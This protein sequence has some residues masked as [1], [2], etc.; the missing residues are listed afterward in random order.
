MGTPTDRPTN[1]ADSF[2]KEMA[3]WTPDQLRKATAMDPTL[4]RM[5]NE[6]LSL[7]I[8]KWQPRPDDPDQ[9][10]EQESFVTSTAKFAIGLGG[11][12]AGKTSAAAYK[13]ARYVL[14]KPAPRRDTP[15]W[16]I[17]EGYDLTCAVC[18]EEKLRNFIPESAI[19]EIDWYKKSR[20]WPNAVVLKD[21]HNTGTNWV[22]EFK[23]YMQGRSRMQARSIGGFWFNEEVPF[24]I[25][26]EVQARCRDYDSPGWADFTPI[27]IRDQEWPDAYEDPPEGWEFFHLNTAC[28]KRLADGWFERWI[29]SIPADMRDTRQYGTFATFKGQIFKEW[30][31]RHNII[32]WQKPEDR[33]RTRK[34]CPWLTDDLLVWNEKTKEY[35]LD[36]IKMHYAIPDTW[37]RVRGMDFGFNDPTVCVWLVKDRDQ[38]WFVVDEHFLNQATIA[39]HAKAINARPWSKHPIFG[40]TFADHDRQEREEYKQYGIATAAA[41]KDL[42]PGI[43]YVRRLMMLQGDGWPRLFVFEH[44]EN[45][46]REHRSYKWSMPVGEGTDRERNPIDLPHDFNNHTVDAVRYALYSEFR[47]VETVGAPLTRP[48]R[49]WEQEA[50]GRFL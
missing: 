36:L 16:I 34:V 20:N 12:G 26:E 6:L 33:E 11:N 18:W 22:L 40:N 32:R 4:G 19:K 46:I 14:D 48:R 30:N 1:R 35:D 29:K 25:V 23:S 44:C 50:A 39:T 7:E 41:K 9:F 28:N 43:D 38:R 5:L 49:E 24:A 37:K 17:G 8:Y 2:L 47:Q 27:E 42:I 3:N 31:S 13:T 21:I 45:T 10:D 15:F